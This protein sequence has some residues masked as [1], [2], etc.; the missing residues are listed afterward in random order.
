[1][2]TQARKKRLGADILGQVIILCF[3]LL[4]IKW[5]VLFLFIGGAWQLLSFLVHKEQRDESI[6]SINKLYWKL[7]KGVLVL[8]LIAVFSFGLYVQVESNVF[9]IIFF[10]SGAISFFGGIGLYLFYLFMS[11]KELLVINKNESVL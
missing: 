5:F 9:G 1:M 3:S 8:M 6:L 11:M 7:T 10:I 2:D 4:F